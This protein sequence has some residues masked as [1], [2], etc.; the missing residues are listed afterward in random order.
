MRQKQKGGIRYKDCRNAL[1]SSIKDYE[2]A[3]VEEAACRSGMDCIVTRN[4]KDFAAGRIKIYS[5]G[6]LIKVMEQAEKY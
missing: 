1:V 3:V 2:D 5:P 6:E 4:Q